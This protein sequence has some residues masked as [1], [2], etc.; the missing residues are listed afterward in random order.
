MTSRLRKLILIVCAILLG[1]VE[2]QADVPGGHLYIGVGASASKPLASNHSVVWGPPNDRI[3]PLRIDY[4][5]SLEFA[6]ETKCAF[7]AISL[8]QG[9]F[10]SEQPTFKLASL[11]GGAIFGG[12]SVGPYVGGGGGP[13]WM[14][15]W[16]PYDNGT[17]VHASGFALLAEAGV[18]FFRQ[19]QVGRVALALRLIEPLFGFQ[20]PSFAGVGYP[21]DRI[22]LL[23]FTTRVFF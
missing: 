15:V 16:T 1:A 10:H 21:P 8:E 6:F 18:L 9:G 7:A 5:L 20:P 11:R 4:A 17:Q 12:T 2:A 19:E 14:D 22:P 13:M 3:I 23:L